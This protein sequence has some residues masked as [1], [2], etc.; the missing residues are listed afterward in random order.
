MK[1]VPVVTVE[2]MK[3]AIKIGERGVD[4]PLPDFM[5]NPAGL[6]IVDS[7]SNR[8][9]VAIVREFGDRAY[10]IMMRI[11]VLARNADCLGEYYRP[12]NLISELAL[13]AVAEIPIINETDPGHEAIL[14]AIAARKG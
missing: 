10:A 3:R 1:L 4:V 8:R 13:A 12:P 6:S 2:E 9:D 14:A 7:P 11:S 5:A